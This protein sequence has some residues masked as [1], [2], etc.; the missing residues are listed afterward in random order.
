MKKRIQALGSAVIKGAGKLFLSLI[1]PVL[2]LRTGI[3]WQE[4]RL[5]TKFYLVSAMRFKQFAKARRVFHLLFFKVDWKRFSPEES[6]FNLKNVPP[7]NTWEIGRWYA[8]SPDTLTGTEAEA[9]TPNRK[10]FSI[11][12]EAIAHILQTNR[13]EKKTALLPV[14]TCFTVLDPFIQEGWE[15]HF[16]RYR[17]NLTV[18]DDYFLEV[19]R[20]SRPSLCLFQALSGFGFTENEQKLI[21]YAHQ[22]R[23]MTVVDQTQD[24]YNSQ[25][26]PAVDY[27][28]GS[29]RKWYPFPD[30]SFLYSEKHLIGGCDALLENNIYRTAMGLCMFARHL[31]SRYNDPFFGY[32]YDFMW[33]F[34]VSYIAGT[35]I[36]AHTMSDYSRKVLRQQNEALNTK[37]RIEN[38]RYLYQ[39]IKGLST[40]TPAFGELD[41]LQSVPLSFPVYTQNRS[42]FNAFLKARGVRTQILWGVPPYIKA[43][44]PFDKET[45]YTYRHILSLPCDQRYDLDDMKKMAAIICAYDRQA[46]G[47]QP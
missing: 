47:K 2:K 18:D 28:C 44:V 5:I 24:V 11:G 40:V 7:K 22:N 30:G 12:R 32:L 33:D 42:D 25:S 38:F 23:S 14:F 4:S 19:Y 31:D 17:R 39:C 41:R 21:A 26:D 10:L 43:H 15:L 45:A 46:Q 27:Y 9:D 37:K 1:S 6:L 34:S 3:T 29:L 20:Q 36:A 35:S 8:L 13:F 16:Y